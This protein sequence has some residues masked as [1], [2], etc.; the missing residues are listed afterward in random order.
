MGL[1]TGFVAMMA[2][3]CVLALQQTAAHEMASAANSTVGSGSDETVA[4]LL[5][6]VQAAVADDPALAAM[7]DVANASQMSEEELTSLLTEIMAVS[8]SGSSVASASAST[9]GSAG[10]ADE[11][12]SASAAG[13]ST[14]SSSAA[15]TTSL[16]AAVALALLVSSLYTAL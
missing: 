14:P 1:R 10:S 11:T 5:A 12:N 3:L 13:S 6:E 15:T 7:F 9:S 4:E 16:S 2:A 8:S